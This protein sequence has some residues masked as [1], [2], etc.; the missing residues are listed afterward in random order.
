[1]TFWERRNSGEMKTSVGAWG[2][3]AGMEERS[4]EDFLGSENTLY[5]T[6][7]VGTC[8]YTFAHT[9]RMYD[10]KSEPECD[11]W[12]L[13]LAMDA[14]RTGPLLRSRTP[15]LSVGVAPLQHSLR[16]KY[17]S[18]HCPGEQR[19]GTPSFWKFLA[20]VLYVLHSCLLLRDPG[21][22][23]QLTLPVWPWCLG[24]VVFPPP[25]TPS[26][27]HPASLRKSWRKLNEEN[28]DSSGQWGGKQ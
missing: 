9:H 5:A 28:F 4:T 25:S 23:F 26:L 1:M 13:A 16:E 15:P 12:A 18:M 6:I 20:P 10:T 21:S 3:G 17:C 19:R 27:L 11:L 22:S 7:M 8:H 14:H 2:G 24:S